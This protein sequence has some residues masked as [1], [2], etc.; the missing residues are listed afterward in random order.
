MRQRRND[1]FRPRMHRSRRDSANFTFLR[2][3]LQRPKQWCPSLASS[4]QS[5]LH[6]ERNGSME[7]DTQEY[8]QW[9]RQPAAQRLGQMDRDR[10]RGGACSGRYRHCR[11]DEQRLRRSRHGRLPHR[12]PHATHGDGRT[13][14]REH[15]RRIDATPEQEE[16]LWAI[17]DAARA[18]IRPVSGTSATRARTSPRSSARRSSTAPPPRNCA[19]SASRPSTRPPRRRDGAARRRRSADAGTAGQAGRAFQGAR[20]ARPV[21][22]LAVSQGIA[23]ENRLA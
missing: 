13:R 14:A 23:W 12:W 7:Q 21:V 19:A 11:R 6:D 10:R 18:E 4:Q 1:G 22:D 15:A 16:K 17:I 3:R 9:R 5:V 2:I 20:R 8:R